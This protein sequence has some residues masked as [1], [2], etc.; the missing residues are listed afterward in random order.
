MG[1][2]TP[3]DLTAFEQLLDDI[4]LNVRP[5]NMAVAHDAILS[6]GWE[7]RGSLKYEV[8]SGLLLIEAAALA[9]MADELWREREGI[10]A[11][12]GGRHPEVDSEVWAQWVTVTSR[13]NAMV[14]GSRALALAAVEAL[15]NELLAAQ[16][17]DEYAEWETNRRMGFRQ[18]LVNLLELRG[19]D[20]DDLPWFDA[21]DTQVQLR[22]SMIHHRP[23]WTIDDSDE[24]SVAPSDDMTQ[25]SLTET[26]EVVHQ[27][28]GGLFALYGVETPET[29][30][31]EWLKRTAGW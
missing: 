16:N 4:R 18:K 21:L 27:A 15:V 1:S 23:G 22:N 8:Q 28:I 5:P 17:P 20:P 25:E 11:E 24:H 12:A 3:E 7:E 6:A 19:A 26:I 9:E 14:R 31:P 30:R 13:R 2:S 10:L 29:H